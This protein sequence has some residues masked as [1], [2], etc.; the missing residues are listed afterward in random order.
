[1]DSAFSD[2]D[3]MPT[4][5]ASEILQFTVSP[6]ETTMDSPQVK[7]EESQTEEKKPAKKRKSWGQELPTP[8]TNLPPR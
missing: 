5:P 4:T 7:M 3:S 2:L 6:S 8:K 1:M